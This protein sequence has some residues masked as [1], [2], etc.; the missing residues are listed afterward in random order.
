MVSS[1][2]QLSLSTFKS[3]IAY[4]EHNQYAYFTCA[5]ITTSLNKDGVEKKKCPPF[6]NHK[7]FKNHY[8]YET[9]R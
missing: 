3:A 4:Y 7:N 1:K 9:P 2:S 6:P 5:A 8:D